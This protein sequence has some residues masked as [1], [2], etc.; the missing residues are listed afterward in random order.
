MCRL[1]P[2][3]T[4]ISLL[5]VSNIIDESYGKGLDLIQTYGWFVVFTAVAL[6]FAYPYIEVQYYKM[7]ASFHSS[8]L[9]ITCYSLIINFL[10]MYLLQI[11]TLYVVLPVSYVHPLS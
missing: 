1:P 10:P 9:L 6:Y 11:C 2:C 5:V 3:H 4:P 7:L 8:F